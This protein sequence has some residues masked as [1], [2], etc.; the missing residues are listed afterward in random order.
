ML[1]FIELLEYI[2]MIDGEA[3]CSCCGEKRDKPKVYK[4]GE[5]MIVLCTDCES[6]LEELLDE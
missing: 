4:H 6:F 2:G 5:R 1:K 3:T